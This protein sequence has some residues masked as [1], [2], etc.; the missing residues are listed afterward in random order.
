MVPYLG[1]EEHQ[2]MLAFS[3]VGDHALT[4]ELANVVAYW[5]CVYWLL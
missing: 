4:R 1:S 2:S 5:L 3:Q